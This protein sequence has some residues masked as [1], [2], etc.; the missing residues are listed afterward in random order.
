[1]RFRIVQGRRTKKVIEGTLD[2]AIDE[3]KQI[4]RRT[5][6]VNWLVYPVLIWEDGRNVWVAVLTDDAN[7][8]SVHHLA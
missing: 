1:M 8:I 6:T 2:E 3:A 5:P 7:A 4:L